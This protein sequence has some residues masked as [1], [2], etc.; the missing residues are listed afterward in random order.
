[1]E[2]FVR[3]PA[4]PLINCLLQKNKQINH[5]RCNPANHGQEE[6][7]GEVRRDKEG[8]NVPKC[9]E[10]L[11]ETKEGINEIHSTGIISK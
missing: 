6:F 9:K 2:C 8:E 4:G 5:R 7:A 10:I 3:S 11:F 1:M